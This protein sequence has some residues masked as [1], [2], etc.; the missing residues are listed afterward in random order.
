[1]SYTKQLKINIEN[2]NNISF[3]YAYNQNS[4]FGDLLE[5]TSNIFP[6]SNICPCFKF[7]YKSKNQKLSDINKK[8]KISEYIFKIN[9][10]YLVNNYSDKK[11]HCSPLFKDNFKI[12]K[13]KY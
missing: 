2:D 9:Q 8:S 4:T 7:Q 3:N 5:F 12:Q 1:M 10:F 6:E 13:L 11:C